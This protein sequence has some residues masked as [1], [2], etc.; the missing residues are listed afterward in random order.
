ML[1]SGL[2]LAWMVVV[3]ALAPLLTRVAWPSVAPKLALLLWQ[4]A[5][6]SVAQSAVLLALVSWHDVFE[7]IAA[8]MFHARD[9]QIDNVYRM[10]HVGGTWF[11]A[12]LV[13]MVFIHVVVVAVREA[14]ALAAFRR[15]HRQ[16][17]D[18]LAP[19]TQDGVQI[20]GHHSP[21]VYCVPGRRPRVVVTT[22]ALDCLT[23]TQLQAALAH[24]RAHLRGRHHWLHLA[25]RACG[26]AVPWLPLT[27][28]FE[29]ESNRLMEMAADDFA[30]RTSGR[31]TTAEALIRI[32]TGGTSPLGSLAAAAADVA[33]RVERL[34]LHR[35]MSR[36]ARLGVG[37][38]ILI[39]VGF[40]LAGTAL[41]GVDAFGPRHLVSNASHELTT[42]PVP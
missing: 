3:T 8:W 30:A 9:D 28:A 37:A 7:R 1:V 10:V 27:R 29:T 14:R 5:F 21:A 16:G 42:R 11:V 39:L 22:G 25:G 36:G 41:P 6:V 32:S 40:P 35:R 23:A 26:R 12:A 31:Q 20:L 19:G 33:D 2:L 38:V 4:A 24:E 17:L 34:V 18:L 15:T 13:L